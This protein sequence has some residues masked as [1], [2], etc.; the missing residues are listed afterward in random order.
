VL[1]VQLLR[2][3]CYVSCCACD[4]ISAV[5]RALVVEYIIYISQS[6]WKSTNWFSYFLLCFNGFYMVSKACNRTNFQK[7]ANCAPPA[8]L[9]TVQCSGLNRPQKVQNS[10]N[11]MVNYGFVLTFL[12]NC[13]N[14]LYNFL[15]KFFYFFFTFMPFSF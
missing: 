1:L 4:L 3:R 13:Y 2:V 11:N 9:S 6:L 14:F 10:N 12:N 5:A 7:T 8:P 15:Y